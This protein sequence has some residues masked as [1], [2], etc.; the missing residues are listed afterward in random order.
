[1]GFPPKRA[2]TR[3][4]TLAFFI[5]STAYALQSYLRGTQWMLNS[6]ELG[7]QGQEIHDTTAENEVGSTTNVT[8]WEILK[9]DPTISKFYKLNEPMDIIYKWLDNPKHI[10]TIYAPIDS[11]WDNQT[12]P[13]EAPDFY[14]S[15]LSLHHMASGWTSYADLAAS[16]TMHNRIVLDIFQKYRQRYTVKDKNGDM[17]F[18]RKAKYVGKESVSSRDLQFENLRDLQIA[19][20][21]INGY[22]H[23]ISGLLHLPDAAADALREWP[24]FRTF[25]QGLMHS[26][27]AVPV[28]NTQGHLTQTIFA[29][30]NE[31]FAKLG[32][33][34][35]KFLFSAWGRPYLAALL[36]YHIVMNHTLYSD[37]YYKRDGKGQ[38]RLDTTSEPVS[39]L[40]LLLFDE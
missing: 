1:M 25:R 19:Q 6:Q 9:N 16:T 2:L 7:N 40:F 30:S 20:K 5:G 14:W 29:P 21:A 33:K 18:N 26:D 12:F 36:K 39:N 37:I 22:V 31:A 15:F 11:A 4:A 27:V 24:Q 32:H 34:V 38:V 3:F 28:N 23:R 10:F 17:L 8:V 35:N 13:S